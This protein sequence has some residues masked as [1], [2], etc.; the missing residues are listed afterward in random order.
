MIKNILD[1]LKVIEL[2]FKIIK[3]VRN[4]IKKNSR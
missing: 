1:V 2:L 3:I 4:Y